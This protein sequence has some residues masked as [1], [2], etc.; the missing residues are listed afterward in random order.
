MKNAMVDRR[1]L[2][3][4]TGAA[5]IAG[6]SMSVGGLALA[7]EGTEG[8][9]FPARWDAEADAI[10]IGCGCAGSV[11]AIELARR[12]VSTL[13]LEKGDRETAGGCCSVCDGYVIPHPGSTDP[14]TEEDFIVSSFGTVDAAYAGAVVPYINDAPEYLTSIGVDMDN[15][16]FP[17]MAVPRGDSSSALGHALYSSLVSVIEGYSDEITVMYETPGLALIQDPATGE[18]LGVKGGSEESPS[19]FKARLGVI[20]AS[21]GYEADQEMLSAAHI[22]GIRIASM[23]S[24]ANTGDGIKML[25]KAGC[26]AQSYAKCLEYTSFALKAASEEMGTALA[27]PKIPAADSYVFVNCEGRRF[28]D[29]TAEIMHSKTDSVLSVNSF[30]GDLYSD[31]ST[32]RYINMPAFIVFDE[33]MRSAGAVVR[34]PGKGLAGWNNAI[35]GVHNLWA[36]SDDNLAEIDKGWIIRADT[37]EE[38]AQACVATDLWGNEVHVDPQGLID[39]VER[40]NQCCQDGEDGEFGRSDNSLASLSAEGPYYAA[41]LTPAI[42]YTVGGASHD[43]HAQAVDWSGNPIARLYMAGLVGDPFTL[44]TPGLVGAVAWGRIAA[45]TVAGLEPRE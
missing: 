35:D 15:E 31:A 7:S 29:E 34:Q 22:P 23:G 38:L 39:Q 18:V 5:A 13:V 21:G 33:A 42:T 11:A 36:W 43:V 40:Y 41:E 3:K 32:S 19:Y 2:V 44:H 20:V 4:G 25:M 37:L 16:S 28:M 9:W 27:L 12:G 30:Q 45:E 26:K 8:S 10:V 6:A 17:G 14:L 24:P 1:S